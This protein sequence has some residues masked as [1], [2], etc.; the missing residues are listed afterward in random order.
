MDYDDVVIG[1]GHNG[2][3][4]A[5]Y[6]ARAGRRV[7][8]LEA[9]DHVGGAAVSA[10]AF[11][12]VDARLSRYSYLVSLLPRQVVGDLDLDLR[13][14]RRRFS[15]FT[16]V[17]ADPA[18]GLLVDNADEAATAAGFA[19]LTGGQ[20]E[21]AAW[22]DFYG[23]VQ[24][25]AGK[26]FPTVLEPLRTEEDLAALVGDDELWAA[27]VRRPLGEVLEERF[28]DDTVRGV[29]ATD[30]LIGT[31]A[32]LR[33]DD[34]RQNVCFL[35]HLIGGGTGDWDVPVGG[36]GAVTEGLARAATAAGA[37]IRTGTRV[38]AVDPDG[39]VDWDGGSARAST[40]HAA[41]AP[42][43]LNELLAA[44]GADPV[45][46]EAQ[47]E[48]AQLKVNMLLSRLP[49]LRDEAVDPRAAFAGTFHVNE[50]Y[51]QLQEA[52]AAAADGRVP[53]V[54]PCEIYC[55][56]LSDRSILGPGLAGSDAQTLTLFGLHLPARLFRG[57]QEQHDQVKDLA[58]ARTLE[59]LNSV[60][61][62][63][64]QDVLLRD[65]D[66]AYCLEARTPVELEADLGLPGGNI[67]HR[68]L[69]WPW[70]ERPEEVG[71]WGVETRHEKVRLAGAGARRGGGVSGIPGHNAA[72][73]VL[74]G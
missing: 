58:L 31:F 22:Q 64:I 18:R 6:L 63:P 2:L 9:A 15:S 23:R 33:G 45:E 27:L 26:V 53:Q 42:A 48:G 66:G 25:V 59:S 30:A 44:A 24:A 17:P 65:G 8:V 29:V 71:T 37:E 50:G 28:A 73:S 3:T 52:Y 34:L 36:M 7:L 51:A 20:G 46:T 47:P 55:H 54:P 5:A 38:L 11:A 68:S 49:R 69:Q 35:Y 43:V 67:F 14:I 70:A 10:Q 4:A 41:C 40:V 61:A 13:L 21:H 39:T 16:P 19:A 1:A 74:E 62:E 12:G 56:S 72:R 60:L 57:S 32:D